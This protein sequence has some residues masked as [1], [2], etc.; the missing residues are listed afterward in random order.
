M[1]ARPLL[2]VTEKARFQRPQPRGLRRGC[3][4]QLSSRLVA[5]NTGPPVEGRHPGNEVSR[6]VGSVQ[7]AGPLSAARAIGSQKITRIDGMIQG[8]CSRSHTTVPNSAI[9]LH[10]CSLQG[11]LS[12][13]RTKHKTQT[14]NRYSKTNDCRQQAG[15]MRRANQ[16]HK[17]SNRVGVDDEC[18]VRAEDEGS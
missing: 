12:G 13:T 18:G 1:A 6:Q 9:M 8:M 3:L 4:G 5:G 11:K 14:N 16:S 15:G 7:S 10:S 2:L 17:L